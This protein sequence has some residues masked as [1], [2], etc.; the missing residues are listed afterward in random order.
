MSSKDRQCPSHEDSKAI[1]R[2]VAYLEKLGRLDELQSAVMNDGADILDEVLKTGAVV[3]VRLANRGNPGVMRPPVV[4]RSVDAWTEA[5]DEQLRVRYYERGQ[6]FPQIAEAMGRSAEACR[7]RARRLGWEASYELT[8]WT[9]AED[10]A[11]AALV[12][13][14]VGSK[15]IAAEVGRSLQAVLHRMRHLH[16][17]GAIATEKSHHAYTVADMDALR[18][19]WEAGAR[20][21]EIAAALGRTE[22]SV[23]HQARRLGLTGTRKSPL[24]V[25]NTQPPRNLTTIGRIAERRRLEKLRERTSA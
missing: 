16:L 6:T 14:K 25:Y 20:I 23:T 21:R 24:P 9:D 7:T 18:T 1:R 10:E 2:A 3:R 15:R 12:A 19:Q 8:R 13:A 22:G 4:R 5:M 11:L 17:T